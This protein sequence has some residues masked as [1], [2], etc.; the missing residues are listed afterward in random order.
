MGSEKFHLSKEYVMVVEYNY[1]IIH[2]SFENALNLVEFFHP[3]I[4]PSVDITIRKDFEQ[5]HGYSF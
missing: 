5:Y 1:S 4:L 2:I 3:G